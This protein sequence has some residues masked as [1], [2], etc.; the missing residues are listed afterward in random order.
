[1]EKERLTFHLFLS[2]KQVPRTKYVQEQG[3]KT[4]FSERPYSSFPPQVTPFQ[5]NFH[6]GS[7][8]RSSITFFFAT[9]VHHSSS[10]LFP[11]LFH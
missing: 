8:Q 4:T 5:L 3:V 11:L 10:S 7:N 9:P 2:L 1:M 6:V